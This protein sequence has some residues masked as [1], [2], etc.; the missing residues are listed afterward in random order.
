MSI[1]YQFCGFVGQLQTEVTRHSDLL[2]NSGHTQLQK[3]PSCA[4][5]PILQTTSALESSQSHTKETLTGSLQN[6]WTPPTRDDNLPQCQPMTEA[7]VHNAALL[8]TPSSAS[9]SHPNSTVSHN[10]HFTIPQQILDQLGSYQPETYSVSDHVS[11]TSLVMTP[12][13][14]VQSGAEVSLVSFVSH[15]VT[16]SDPGG[17]AEPP[18]SAPSSSDRVRFRIGILLLIKLLT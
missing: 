7:L 15:S 6:V 12:P 13:T 1:H 11:Q 4:E 16:D 2:L 18:A 17:N 14:N 8:L 9:Y 3:A 10:Q 5:Q